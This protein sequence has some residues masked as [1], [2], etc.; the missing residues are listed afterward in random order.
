MADN[1]FSLKILLAMPVSYLTWG[2]GC[3]GITSASHVKAL[4]SNPTVSMLSSLGF[5][6]LSGRGLRPASRHILVD[7]RGLAVKGA[8]WAWP[9]L[10]RFPVGAGAV[11]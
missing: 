11:A 2:T 8:I 1:F 6:C 3:N 7:P 9:A 10:V 4:G 5:V